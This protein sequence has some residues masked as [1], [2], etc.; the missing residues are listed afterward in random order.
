MRLKPIRTIKLDK[1]KMLPWLFANLDP[2]LAFRGLLDSSLYDTAKNLYESVEWPEELKNILLNRKM[3]GKK[4]LADKYNYSL[5]VAD[6]KLTYYQGKKA[7][8]L[9]SKLIK[10]DKIIATARELRGNIASPGKVRGCVKIVYSYKD[11]GKVNRGDILVAYMTSPRLMPALLKCGAIITND[12][13]LTCHAA[14]IAREL[15]KPCI[16]GTK[17]AT[18]VLKDGD[19]VE[20]DANKGIV[21][22]IS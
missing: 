4:Y 21:K 8:S 11:M 13:G 9:K 7:L 14:I 12:G 18:K 3:Y 19:I 1:N 5:L 16:I 6:K 15:N 17:I 20:V 22:K 10:D 2:M